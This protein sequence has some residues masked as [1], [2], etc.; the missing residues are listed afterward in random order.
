MGLS[1]INPIAFFGL[2]IALSAVITAGTMFILGRKALH[3]IWG[4]FCL[5]VCVW[6]GS[7]YIIAQTHDPVRA[8]LWWKISHVGVI[9]IPI[10]FIHFVYSFLGY[11]DTRHRLF[12]G[13]SYAVGAFLLFADAYTSWLIN[14][15]K[16][17]FG[18]F[19][20]VYPPTA[21]YW[22]L[23]IFFQILIVYGHIE[24]IWTYFHSADKLQKAQIRYLLAATVLG[25]VGGGISFSLAFGINIYPITIV[26]VPL[27]PIITGYA[28]LK[29]NLFNLKVVTAQITTVLIFIFTFI[30]LFTST[31][32]QDYILNGG[33]LVI[34]MA[35]GIYL[36]RSVTSEVEQR[37]RSEKLAKE[38]GEN[39][40][41]LNKQLAEIERMNKYMVDR[42]LKMVE[43]KKENESLQH[44]NDTLKKN[45]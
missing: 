28:I 12:L 4:V 13:A 33:L 44:E 10:L 21:L 43:L 31:S 24:L 41:Q 7:F 9:L 18:Q 39:A 23:F 35:L 45:T 15:V 40:A 5:A 14:N 30:R 37:E 27:Y 34:V 11:T 25:F 22:F 42:E 2:A 36:S 29:Y 3:I 20:W 38:V 32:Y 26:T 16:F 19:Y 8:L 6:G 1:A 17:V